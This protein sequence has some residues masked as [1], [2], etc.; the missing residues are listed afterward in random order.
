MISFIIFYLIHSILISKLKKKS[1]RFSFFLSLSSIITFFSTL[2][3]SSITFLQINFIAFL[4]IPISPPCSLPHQHE[5]SRSFLMIMKA[6]LSTRTH[7]KQVLVSLISSGCVSL[8]F[9]NLCKLNQI[10]FNLNYTLISPGLIS[11]EMGS[12]FNLINNRL[13]A[14]FFFFFLI[15]FMNGCVLVLNSIFLIA[16]R[17]QQSYDLHSYNNMLIYLNIPS[18]I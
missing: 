3:F 14:V 17:I 6:V 7:Y 4:L 9:L 16:H 13:C 5:H 2:S 12:C 15:F 10:R 1:L 8:F 18:Q 11:Y